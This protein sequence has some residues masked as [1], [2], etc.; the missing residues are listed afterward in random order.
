[1]RHLRQ[2]GYG[3]VLYRF[4]KQKPWAWWR[5]LATSTGFFGFHSIKK[6]VDEKTNTKIDQS[7]ARK[8][9]LGTE[10]WRGA[11][12]GWRQGHDGAAA[13]V[14]LEAALQDHGDLV[15]KPGHLDGPGVFVQ[16]ARLFA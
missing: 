11:C 10:G 4:F 5:G 9:C 12:R 7:L 2:N 15:T 6:N 3:K 16:N 8:C 14:L 1:M 13:A